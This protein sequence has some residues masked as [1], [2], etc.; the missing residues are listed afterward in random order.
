MRALSSTPVNRR[1]GHLLYYQRSEF[2]REPGLRAFDLEVLNPDPIKAEMLRR[3]GLFRQALDTGDPAGLPRC[4]WYGRDCLYA[5]F[6]GCANARSVVRMVTDATVRMQENR[7]LAAE[8]ETKIRA[9]P[10][11]QPTGR[12]S[13]NDLVFPRKAVLRTAPA[14]DEDGA[15]VGDRMSSM[16]RRGFLDQLENAVWY[17][18]PGACKR[19]K[20]TFG[21]LHPSILLFRDVPTLIRST[22]RRTMIPRDR[23][24]A[25][26]PYY[27]DR[28]AFEC[29]V[30]GS[31]KGRLII[32]YSSL[33]DDKFMVYDFWLSDLD[34]VRTEMQ[35][36][37]GLLES[38]APVTQLP[39][40][41]P[42]WMASLCSY[43]ER[44][45]CRTDAFGTAP[46]V[47][48]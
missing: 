9:T 5:E 23:L 18:V 48:G 47:L 19:V 31:K 2:G 16:E 11:A 43:R 14:A 33:P 17:G 40:C 13:L 1:L 21:S 12:F 46:T 39:P 10:E 3:H 15:E 34:A 45:A 28:L 35:R 20:F 6:C 8:I 4:E 22:R 26:A 24:H 42:D 27:T 44:C 30:T 37:L 38:G 41:E 7:S 36:R 32:Y 25:D 29:A